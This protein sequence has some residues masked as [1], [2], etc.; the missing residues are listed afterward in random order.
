MRP[1]FLFPALTLLECAA[2][3]V[4]LSTWRL[5]RGKVSCESAL[6]VPLPAAVLP[7]TAWLAAVGAA[8]RT[9][10][11][12]KG[13]VTL[14]VPPERTWTKM[15]RVPPVG[16]AQREKILRFELAQSLPIPPEELVWG[17]T[18][19]DGPGDDSLTT[20][21]AAKLT[22]IDALQDAALAAGFA[23]QAVRPAQ[24]GALAAFQMSVPDPGRAALVVWST[25]AA[26][27]LGW[28]DP[29]PQALRVAVG[30][31][32]AD[33]AGALGREIARTLTLF[34]SQG[35]AAPVRRIY[36]NGLSAEASAALAAQTHVPVEIWPGLEKGESLD[37]AGPSLIARGCAALGLQARRP[38]V[39]LLSPR[40]RRAWQ[41]R[42]RRPW[43]IA[44]ALV[45]LA[46]LPPPLW[47]ARQRLT[48]MRARNA[49]LENELGS[50]RAQ[51]A[52]QR[53]MLA[54]IAELRR[55]V[56]AW[57]R[58]EQQRTQ[59]V[60][61]LADCQERLLAEGD[62][63]IETVRLVPSDEGAPARLAVT[64][65]LIE[66]GRAEANDH[67]DVRARVRRLRA[68][69]A[70]SPFVTAIATERYDAG[71]PGR[72]RFDWVLQGNFPL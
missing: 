38:S 10:P 39:D 27:V 37:G 54:R 33:P 12:G 20:V 21:I 69:F 46:A 26:T 61:W 52:R 41:R 50:L 29:A 43:L 6:S 48:A 17:E 58:L 7:E 60:L 3:Q 13:P 22:V 9:L 28:F 19:P 18:G 68:R 51:A 56:E 5:R 59:W 72:L 53:E 15:H 64:G 42:Q 63:W 25:E 16:R 47:E 49:A 57:G 55:D 4:T 32:G 24:L 31:L 34:Q 36:L 71:Q 66:R 23:V 35:A 14:I 30:R 40:H 62:G 8:F 44:A 70:S 2:H 11:R 65:C 67:A 1:V 45:A